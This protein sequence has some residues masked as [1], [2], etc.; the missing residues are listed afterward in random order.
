MIAAK[1]IANAL[2]EDRSKDNVLRIIQAIEKQG[3]DYREFFQI[4]HEQ[5]ASKCWRMTWMLSSLV[6]RNPKIGNEIQELVW[7]QLK[8][9]EHQGMQRDLWRTLTFVDI[10]EELS[11]SV[12]DFAC[13]VIA[14]AHYPVAVRVHAMQCAFNI[15]KPWPELRDELKMILDSLGPEESVGTRNRAGKLSARLARIK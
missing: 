7:K 14:S 3:T 9:C 1:D 12:Y 10:S 5:P 6:E 4:V 13:N 15:A 11:G 8:P 2:D